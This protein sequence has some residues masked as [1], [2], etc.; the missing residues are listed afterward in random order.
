MPTMSPWLPDPNAPGSSPRDLLMAAQRALNQGKTG[1]AQEALERAETRVLSRTTDPSMAA[2]PDQ[3][4]MVQNIAQARRALGARDTAGAKQ[5][6]AMA[7]DDRVPPRGPATTT[8][9]AG[10]PSG[11]TF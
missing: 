1:A 5:A 7:M 6:I 9:P 3:T 4:S 11:G 2:T 8:G 10:V